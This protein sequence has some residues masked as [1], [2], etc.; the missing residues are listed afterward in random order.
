MIK[1]AQILGKVPKGRLNPE[2]W[3]FLSVGWP[4]TLLVSQAQK[5][6]R[7]CGSMQMKDLHS[8]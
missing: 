2:I 4:H 5:L 8:L 1:D 6:D 3:A 7:T